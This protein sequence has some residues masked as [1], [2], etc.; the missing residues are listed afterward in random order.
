MLVGKESHL[1]LPW[2]IKSQSFEA[3]QTS[4]AVHP[5]SVSSSQCLNL[6]F[7]TFPEIIIKKN[8][9]T[10]TK[11]FR[12]TSGSSY[13]NK[14]QFSHLLLV[15]RKRKKVIFLRDSRPA[16]QQLCNPQK[17]ALFSGS[18]SWHAVTLL[19]SQE[20]GK[21]VGIFP[22]SEVSLSRSDVREKGWHTPSMNFFWFFFL[23]GEV[24]LRSMTLEFWCR[25]VFGFVPGMT[26]MS[27]F[28]LAFVRAV[29]SH[30]AW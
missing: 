14:L 1:Q 8:E 15:F 28:R 6:T 16:V 25:V 18:H 2:H 29:R 30:A 11:R 21:K 9:R 10:V 24:S 3:H 17:Y 20:R 13:N 7:D 12:D 19:R 27:G 26:F 5:R 23:L 22:G 4:F